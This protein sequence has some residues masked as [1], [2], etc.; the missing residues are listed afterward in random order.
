M[1]HRLSICFNQDDMT[2]YIWLKVA[3]KQ[4]AFQIEQKEEMIS[5]EKLVNPQLEPPK[6]QLKSIIAN[7]FLHQRI[8]LGHDLNEPFKKVVRPA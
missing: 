7:Y 6:K 1:V 3:L 8:I 2:K 4:K 5:H